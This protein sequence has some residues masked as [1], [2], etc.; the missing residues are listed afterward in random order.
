MSKELEQL[1]K[2]MLKEVTEN[3][4]SE[5][6]KIERDELAI[7]K[8]CSELNL[9]NTFLLIS[10]DHENGRNVTNIRSSTIDKVVLLGLL[11]LTKH[12]IINS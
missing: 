1:F 7:K 5:A 2:G 11:E 4:D 3:R 8:L 6:D 9:G 12:R 10:N